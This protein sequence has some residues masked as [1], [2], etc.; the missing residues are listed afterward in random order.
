[1]MVL[2]QSESVVKFTYQGGGMPY[3][4]EPLDSNVSLWY[5]ILECIHNI[6]R[7]NFYLL[8]KYIDSSIR[9]TVCSNVKCVC[10]NYI[11]LF[12]FACKCYTI[13]S[14]MAISC[15]CFFLIG[16]ILFLQIRYI[17]SKR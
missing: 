5:F 4:I 14:R 3:N 17:A 9:Q 1:M 8:S 11:C 15:H 2:N 7:D 13:C 6:V 10:N 16:C 12:N